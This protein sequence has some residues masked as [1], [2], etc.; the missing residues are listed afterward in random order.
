MTSKKTHHT[1]ILTLTKALLLWMPLLLVSPAKAYGYAGKR[2]ISPELFLE[3]MA[4]RLT[5]PCSK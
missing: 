3:R 5:G 4:M 1:L 2:P